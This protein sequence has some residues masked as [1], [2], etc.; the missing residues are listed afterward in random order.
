[1]KKVLSVLLSLTLIIC[2][3]FAFGG[4]GDKQADK[5]GVNGGKTQIIEE[6]KEKYLEFYLIG[7]HPDATVD[8][9]TVIKYYGKF[10]DSYVALI[11]DAYHEYL[12]V[13]TKEEIEGLVFSYHNSNTIKV[14]N[15]SQ[16]YRLEEAYSNSF[17]TLED[18]KKIN[19]QFPTD[20]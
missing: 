16:F 5:Q 7:E 3:A 4:C 18:L 12:D 17:L 11:T 10:G 9:I 14:L 15:M 2:I 8:N 6:I 19:N 1:M 13:I 20:L